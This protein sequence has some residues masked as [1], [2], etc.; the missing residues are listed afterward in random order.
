[1]HILTNIRC[2]ESR[3]IAPNWNLFPTIRNDMVEAVEMSIRLNYHYTYP[4]IPCQRSDWIGVLGWPPIPWHMQ[5]ERGRP[6]LFNLYGPHTIILNIE[7]SGKNNTK[8]G[9]A[10]SSRNSSFVALGVLRSF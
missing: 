3:K 8:T 7:I 9:S 4:L 2:L 1:M 6:D 5:P 10:G